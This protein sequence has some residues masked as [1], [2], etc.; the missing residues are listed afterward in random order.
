[1]KLHILKTTL[2]LAALV[3]SAINS[4]W[5]GTLKSNVNRNQIGVNET[6]TLMVSYDAQ[7]DSSKLD[8]SSLEQDFEVFNVRPRSN[9]SIS[10]VNG[11]R[12]QV[13]S[14][15]WTITLVPRK[16]GRLTIPALSV[17]GDSSQAISI[18]V[19]NTDNGNSASASQP[20]QAWV[21]SN[22]KVAYPG[23][24]IIIE[25]EL[26]AQNGVSN[27]NG[28][29]LVVNNA[30]VEPLGQQSFQKAD[31]GVA[32]QIVKL[33]YAVFPKS[34]GELII[35]IMTYTGLIGAQGSL[36]GSRGQQIVARSDQLKIRVNSAPEKDS[37]PWFPAENVVISS[38]WSA[39]PKAL[40]I[41]E[42]ITRTITI[43]SVAQRSNVIPPL[44]QI[45]AVGQY[46]TYKDQ[47]QLDSKKSERG[48]V[49]T[50]VESEAIVASSEGELQLAEVKLPW[51]DVGAKR[52]KVAVLPAETIVVS[53]TAV[54]LSNDTDLS[55]GN[56][57]DSLKTKQSTK[58]FGL[59]H[60]WQIAAAV[61]GLM[62]VVQFALI[63]KLR[64]KQRILSPGIDRN[65]SNKVAE[66][67]KWRALNQQLKGN[68]VS[69]IRRTL[70]D[71]SSCYLT[72]D[73]PSTLDEAK[74]YFNDDSLNTQLSQLDKSL[75]GLHT[76]FDS[77]E[78]LATLK[79]LRADASKPKAS[80]QSNNAALKPLYKNT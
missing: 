44:P 1:M 9:S 63:L 14:T 73:R 65:S 49:S 13:A 56:F 25:V 33:K 47:A 39:E 8:V 70:L 79:R 50:R 69:A 41:G 60:F 4:S 78:L 28:P 17:N 32:R 66:P 30:D 34:A 52:W 15:L 31:N 48:F 6:L 19:S 68:D 74:R 38:K 61:L 72:D 42:P 5:A 43:T 59:D 11:K 40:K 53:G 76:E 12:T 20:L 26:S 55:D 7:V 36:F 77:A 57:A 21:S 54:T 18:R 62:V 37:A 10:I 71:W 45:D 80:P 22:N 64:A 16:E 2:L 58:I 67:A 24:Q 29:E 46:K 35:P 3:I 23:Q 75:F 51:F 27:L